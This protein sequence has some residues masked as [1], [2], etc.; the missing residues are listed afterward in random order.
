M[1]SDHNEGPDKERPEKKRSGSTLENPAAKA[2][3]LSEDAAPSSPTSSFQARVVIAVNVS[4]R[5]LVPVP[6]G[7]VTADIVDK[8]TACLGLGVKDVVLV[9]VLNTDVVVPL[10]VGLVLTATFYLAK[11][12]VPVPMYS[13]LI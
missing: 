11:K 1:E 8:I 10:S 13:A 4:G 3:K 9:D 2:P 5:P 6:G 7:Q 12:L